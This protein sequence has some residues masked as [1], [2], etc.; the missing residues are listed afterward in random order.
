MPRIVTLRAL[1]GVACGALRTAWRIVALLVRGDDGA[2]RVE[3]VP[4]AHATDP[5]RRS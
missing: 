4:R 5:R 1:R 2:P 3:P